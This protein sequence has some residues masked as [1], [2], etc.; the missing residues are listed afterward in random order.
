MGF[1][2]SKN[3]AMRSRSS[4]DPLLLSQPLQENMV[5]LTLALVQES[6]GHG[7]PSIVVTSSTSLLSDQKHITDRLCSSNSELNLNMG[8]AE[9]RLGFYLKSEKSLLRLLGQQFWVHM[10]HSEQG[11][12]RSHIKVGH[13][14]SYCVTPSLCI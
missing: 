1:L 14:C 8:V 9:Q 3:I 10:C 2:G 4:E 12:R 5:L 13:N 11:G 6:K 7:K